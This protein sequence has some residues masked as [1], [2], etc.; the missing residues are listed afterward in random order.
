MSERSRQS[1]REGEGERDGQARG[2]GK[3]RGGVRQESTKERKPMR[4]GGACTNRPA[5]SSCLARCA[6]AQGGV[7]VAV[8]N[9]DLLM[10]NVV[11]A[12]GL[13]SESRHQ[14]RD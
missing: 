14:H 6:R 8:K 2:E 9:Q 4:G 1:E 3:E 7:L 13:L 12:K 10:I 11:P 5:S